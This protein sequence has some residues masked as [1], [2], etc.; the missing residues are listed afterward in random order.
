MKHSPFETYVLYSALKL[1]FSSKSYDFFKY[2]GAMKLTEKNF[3]ARNDKY[4]FQKL[5][6]KYTTDEMTDFLVSNIIAGRSWVGKFLDEGADETF[7]LYLKRKQSI[8]YTVVNEVEEA[9]REVGRPSAL[10]SAEEDEYPPIITK[11]MD[12]SMSPETLIVLD[13]FVGFSQKFDERYGEDDMLW[14][15][16]RTLNQKLKPFVVY[17]KDKLK[18]GLKPLLTN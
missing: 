3:E 8:T 14:G 18:A 7:R 11:T 4:H 9:L 13:R 12:G 16:I 5:A 17:D 2:K 15:K 1:H 6:K 10:F